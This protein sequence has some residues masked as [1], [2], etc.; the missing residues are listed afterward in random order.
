[1]IVTDEPAPDRAQQLGALSTFGVPGMLGF[2]SI[3]PG[4]FLSS[5]S[6]IIKIPRVLS[7]L[8]FFSLSF[9]LLP[10]VFF[11]FHF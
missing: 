5:F 10:V 8:E 1:M 4:Q 3:K 6:K 7:A 2:R 9:H 11:F